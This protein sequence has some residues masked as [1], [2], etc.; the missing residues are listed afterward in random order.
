MN[1]C[2]HIRVV[3]TRAIFSSCM[4]HKMAECIVSAVEGAGI[5]DEAEKSKEFLALLLV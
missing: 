1:F 5:V 2:D 4:H 3:N